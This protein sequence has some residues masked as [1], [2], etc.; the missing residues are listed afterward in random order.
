MP[1]LMGVTASNGRHSGLPSHPCL[2]RGAN[3]STL[4]AAVDFRLLVCLLSLLA[5]AV[6]W[7]PPLSISRTSSAGMPRL[8]CRGGRHQLARNIYPLTCATHAEC[9]GT[10]CKRCV[11]RVCRNPASSRT[12][13]CQHSASQH[14]CARVVAG[15]EVAERH[16]GQRLRIRA[17]LR[18]ACPLAHAAAGH[19]RRMHVRKRA[20][21]M[22][23]VT[24]RGGS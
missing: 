4:G 14:A 1:I 10:H 8:M 3:C 12:H 15:E 22:L 20:W 19:R 17:R 5:G 13:H 24:G 21:V 2:R 7:M 18:A 11:S 9:H 16:G 6:A 23:A